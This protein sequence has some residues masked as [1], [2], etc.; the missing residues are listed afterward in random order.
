MTHALEAIGWTLIHF[1]WQAAAVAGVCR[2]AHLAM[3]GRSS[4]ARYLLSLGSLLLMLAAALGTLAWE[5]AGNAPLPAANQPVATTSTAAVAEQQVHYAPG[6]LPPSQHAVPPALSL[7]AV[8]PWVDG[9]WLLG[10]IAL[11][12]RSLGGWWLIRRL[13]AD[14]TTEAPDAIRASFARVAAMLGLRRQ[15]LLRVSSAIAGPM[16]VGALRAMVLLPA[17][18]IMSLSIEELEVVLAHELAHVRRADFFWNLV[19][20]FAETVFFFHPAVWWINREIRSARELCCDDLALTVCPDRV[21]YAEALLRLE[22]QRSQPWRLAMALDG[23]QTAHTLRGRIARILGAPAAGHGP[24]PV[25][26]FPLAAACTGCVVLLLMVPQLLASLTPVRQGAAI[27]PSPTHALPAVVATPKLVTI[28]TAVHADLR[29]IVRMTTAPAV[30]VAAA[31]PAPAPEQAS[32]DAGTRDSAGTATSADTGARSNYID[33]MKSAGYDVDLDKL[34]AMKVQDITPAYARAMAQLGFGKPS[35]DD[36]I[37]CKVQGVTPEYI[38]ELKQRGLEVMSLQDAISYRI[39]D[40]SPEFVSGMKDAGFDQLSSKEMLS[41]RVQGITP[42]YARQIK[43][44]FPSVT[45]DQ[46]VQTRIF[47]IDSKFI[48]MVNQHGFKDLSIDKLVKLR[49]SGIFEDESAK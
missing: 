22:E 40:V 16:T 13:R 23:H 25:R 49:I 9:L 26:P 47:N 11:S 14:A 18:A 20:T 36:L 12:C 10:V 27:V 19:Q 41:M 15:V 1:C 44:Q 31:A 39:F 48:A 34:I 7:A 3:T 32:Q 29:P 28:D 35:A 46:L 24:A 33:A 42:E 8:L 38:A 43:Q 17:A 21:A 45:A 37:A 4:N 30:Q 2:F 5:L 6:Y